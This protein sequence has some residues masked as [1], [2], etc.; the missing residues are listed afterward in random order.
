MQL[1]GIGA[2]S[3]FGHR[4]H[5]GGLQESVTSRSCS[6]KNCCLPA[7]HGKK[8]RVPDRAFP[9]RSLS[10]GV[11]VKRLQQKCR[12]L[13]R[14]TS[15][16][17]KIQIPSTTVAAQSSMQFFERIENMLIGTLLFV[18]FVV[19]TGAAMV[20]RSSGIRTSCTARTSSGW[21]DPQRDNDDSP[22]LWTVPTPPSSRQLAFMDGD[23]PQTHD[24]RSACARAGLATSR[25]SS[26]AVQKSRRASSLAASTEAT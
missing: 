10:T 17:T 15:P 13:Q 14:M 22:H 20:R 11:D 4:I 12:S 24:Y 2:A 21:I 18:A 5:H 8:L 6:R 26:L 16:P 1:A 19:A 23:H 25:R 9:I 7:G 3:L